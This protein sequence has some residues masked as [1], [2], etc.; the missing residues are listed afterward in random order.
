MLSHGRWHETTFSATC[1]VPA[2]RQTAGEG[3]HPAS[4][5]MVRRAAAGPR[6]SVRPTN[7]R[8]ARSRSC[9]PDAAS[10]RLPRGPASD[11]TQVSLWSLLPYRRIRR[12]RVCG[13]SS[14]SRPVHVAGSCAETRRLTAK[15][16]PAA[17]A[18]LEQGLQHGSTRVG[19]AGHLPEPL[20][21]LPGTELNEPGT[22]HLDEM[23]RNR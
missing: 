21:K 7:R 16:S 5:T 15:G 14:A 6:P 22:R 23:G 4:G 20:W 9:E 8:P 2:D 19:R 1:D 10:G 11:P 13:R 18:L 3:G 12:S 17:H